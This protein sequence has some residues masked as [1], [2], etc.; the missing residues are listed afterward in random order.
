MNQ[1][2]YLRQ[3]EEELV[4]ALGCTEPVSVAFAAALARK[5]AGCDEP[6]ESIELQAS[7][8][9][10]KNAMSVF[11]PG[12]NDMGAAMAAAL[13]AVGGDPSLDLQVLQNIC[14]EDIITAR[15]LCAEGKVSLD[16]APGARLLC[17]S[18]SRSIRRII[19]DGRSWHG[20]T[21][22][23]WNWNATAFHFE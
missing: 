20:S 19:V 2:Y 8:N 21:I 16:L 15:K 9:I 14:E 18:M 17:T 13:G 7:V 5:E 4:V 1:E 22:L 6:I 23:L 11:I 12:T 10:Y 3:L